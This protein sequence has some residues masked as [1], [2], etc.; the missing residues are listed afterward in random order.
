[1][2]RARKMNKLQKER[3]AMNDR[4]FRPQGELNG[5]LHPPSCACVRCAAG[6]ESRELSPAMREKVQEMID[7]TFLNMVSGNIMGGGQSLHQGQPH[8]LVRAGF[9]AN[10]EHIFDM[11]EMA[12]AYFADEKPE[13]H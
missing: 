8:H 10:M 5:L 1:M 6:R 11:R 3:S 13:V 9:L 4:N 12:T 7:G 2:S